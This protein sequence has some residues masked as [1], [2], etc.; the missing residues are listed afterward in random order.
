MCTTALGACK[1]I[2]KDYTEDHK[3]VVGVHTDVLEAT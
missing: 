3:A 1:K 2:Q